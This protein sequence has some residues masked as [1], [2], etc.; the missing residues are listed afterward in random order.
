MARTWTER[1]PERAS[2]HSDRSP[3]PAARRV[4]GRRVSGRRGGISWSRQPL[5]AIRRGLNR[6]VQ[7]GDPSTAHGVTLG[8]ETLG[9]TKGGGKTGTFPKR[10]N[11]FCRCFPSLGSFGT[12]FPRPWNP[13]VYAT[14]S[15]PTRRPATLSPHTPSPTTLSPVSRSPNIPPPACWLVPGLVGSGTRCTGD[16]VWMD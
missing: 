9:V 16:Y 15:P 12:I 5:H 1:N 11:A 14:R 3:D 13:V 6:F 7:S 10:W 2:C 4:S 8:G